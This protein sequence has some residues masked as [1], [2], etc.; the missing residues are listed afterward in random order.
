M[1]NFSFKKSDT[2][3]KYLAHYR[4]RAKRNGFTL[5][6]ILVVLLIVALIAAVVV[7]PD[8]F[9]VFGTAKSNAAQIQIER[10]GAALDL[11]R[12]EVGRYPTDTEGL[13][14]LVNQPTGV[15]RWNGPYLKN[16]ES[17]VDPWGNQFVYRF[18]GENGAYDLFSYGADNVEGGDGEAADVTNW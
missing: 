11:Y 12:L 16:A 3:T 1:M 18:P 6:E 9:K 15:D 10:I 7:G 17:L 13:T 14:G 8:I 5:L 2:S 4:L